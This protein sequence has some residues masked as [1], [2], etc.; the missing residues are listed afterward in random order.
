MIVRKAEGNPF[1]LEEVIRT[2]IDMG[3]IERDASSGRWHAT[4]E[5]ETVSVPDNIQGVIMARVDRLD[6]QVKQVLRTAAVIGHSFL[7]RV[8]RAVAEAERQL[9][10][11]VAELQA[12]EL[13]REKRRVPELEYIFKHALAQEA[14]YESILLRSRRTLHRRVGEAIESLF[15]DRL[16][17]FYGLLAYHYARAEAWEKAQEYLLKAGDQAGGVAAD[18]EA[19]AHYKDA[20]MAYERAFGESWDPAERAALERKMGEALFRRGDQT[21]ALQYLR[22]A[23]VHCDRPF[24]LSRWGTRRAILRELAAQIGHRILPGLFV[25]QASG[26]TA[27]GVQDQMRIYYVMAWIEVFSDLE[28][29]LM[30]I[31]RFLNSSER[32]GHAQ[33]VAI[34]SSGLGTA[35]DFVSL[36]GLAG[37][38]HRRAL[39]AAERLH[40]PGVLGLAYQN[41]G[42]CPRNNVLSDMR[43]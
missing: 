19:L 2:L 5:I 33:G 10:E 6:E 11:H 25:K 39:R 28:R 4:A 31:L 34:S 13:V 43:H 8:L 37:G 17:E 20:M 40:D 18:A 32:A 16:D 7:Y 35:A 21:E 41:L 26:Q 22:R 38:L 1:F 24:P 30:V 14:T 12:V 3:A 42:V 23:L 29:F 9:D 15:S 36:F 27:P